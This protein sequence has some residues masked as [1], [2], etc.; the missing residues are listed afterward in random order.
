MRI[1]NRAM[2]TF[3][4]S[5]HRLGQQRVRLDRRLVGGEVVGGVVEDRVDVGQIDELLD[6]DRAHRFGVERRQLVVV[7]QHVLARRAARS[8]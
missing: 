7:D 8:P 1:T 4:D 5:L 3:C 6:V 2:P